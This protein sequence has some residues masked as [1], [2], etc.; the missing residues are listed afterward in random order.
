MTV[1]AFMRAAAI[2]P[3]RALITTLPP[4]ERMALSMLRQIGHAKSV[5]AGRFTP[6]FVDWYLS[7]QRDTATMSNDMRMIG[8]L[9]TVTGSV[10]PEL[11]L[12]HDL[13]RRVDVPTYFY[14]GADDPFGGANV[15]EVL[16]E[17]MVDA[18]LDMVADAGHLPWLDDP[19]A[20]GQAIR[21]F[22]QAGSPTDPSLRAARA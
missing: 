9:V 4:N 12:S 5:D 3:L 19:S 1:P 11:A 21:N 22:L 14:W 18:R 7:L 13:L 16:A 6:A 17:T 15:A 20:A 8:S 2:P 10:H